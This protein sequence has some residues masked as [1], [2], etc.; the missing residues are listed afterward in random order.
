MNMKPFLNLF[1]IIFLFNPLFTFSQVNFEKKIK[2]NEFSSF[3]EKFRAIEVPANFP[4]NSIKY[5]NDHQ[6]E[7]SDGSLTMIKTK[8]LNVTNSNFLP[9]VNY[10][11]Q[12]LRLKLLAIFK[13]R[14]NDN[15][16]AIIYNRSLDS[17]FPTDGLG[18]WLILCTFDTIGNLIDTLPLTGY[19]FETIEQ[20]S[21][22]TKELKIKTYRYEHSLNYQKHREV[23]SEYVLDTKTGK[24]LLLN[25][26]CRKV[27]DNPNN[28]S[29]APLEEFHSC[30][31]ALDKN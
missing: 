26:K 12:E 1:V 8:Y 6:K 28:D 22:I 3:L 11:N 5:Y 17:D 10:N 25:S 2:S 16:L 14:L 15:F 20:S 23:Y 18:D 29:F 9:Q 19:T 7:N 13:Y 21:E 30:N 31:K 27:K 4:F 24:I